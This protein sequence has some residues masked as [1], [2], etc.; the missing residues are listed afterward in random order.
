[1][2]QKYRNILFYTSIIGGGAAFIYWI[3]RQGSHLEEGRHIIRPEAAGSQWQA[4]LETITGNFLE[5]LAILL[6]QIIT[7]IIIARLLGWLFRKIGQPAVIGEIIAGIILGP[8]VVGTLFPDFFNGLFPVSSLA[9]LKTISNIGLIL[10][11]FVVGMELDLKVLRTKIHEAVVISHASIIFPFVL[12]MGLAYLLYGSFAP[13]GVPFISFALFM[14]ISMSITA[15]PVLARIVQERGLQKTRLG[16]VVLTCAAVD[17]I[18]AWCL[19][20]VVIAIVKA[21]SVVSSLYTVLFAIMYVIVMIK[22]VRPFLQKISDI[23]SSREN[24]N[25]SVVAVFFL[26]LLLSAF[27]TEIIGIHALFGAFMAGAIMPEKMNFRSIIVEKVEDVAL[28]IFL[29]LFFVYTG[30]R[31]KIGLINEPHLWEVT[32]WIILVAVIGKFAGSA[33]AGRYVG[34][35]TWK[36]SLIVGTLMNTRGLMELVAINIGYDLGVISAEIFTMLVIMAL[37]TTF[38]T[39]PLL[40]LIE[41]I[42]PDKSKKKEIERQQ[43]EGIFKVL[44]AVGK[45]KNG[46][47]F[48]RIAKKVL[49]GA[50]N[51]L[52][53]TAL[54]ITA[55]ADTNPIRSEQFSKEVFRDIENEAIALNVPL[56][57]EYNISDYVSSGIVNEANENGF[58]FLLFGSG[59]SYSEIPFLEDTSL[60]GKIGWLNRAINRIA[61]RRILFYP[62]TL[63]KDKTRYFIENTKCSVGMFINRG[64]S[65]ITTTLILLEVESDGFLLRYA[66]RLLRNANDVTITIYDVNNLSKTNTEIAEALD[67]LKAQF[68]N[69]V[70]ITRR[71]VAFNRFSFMLISYQAW[72]Y[73]DLQKSEE[74]KFIPSTLI[75][76]KKP[77]R[78]SKRTE[79][80]HSLT[81]STEE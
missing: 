35:Q 23:H 30:L 12:G 45:P 4:F 51:T 3:S 57:K 77:S 54:H 37:L 72:N 16:T 63:I 20:A 56:I 41:K 11:M 61:R 8:S 80:I 28:I 42:A 19:L 22:F 65:Q 79:V 34:R 74:L 21:G 66:R 32:G 15:F 49:D 67:N 24:L 76:N 48:L 53:V 60:F 43:A 58:D 25:K 13:M 59:V 1:M 5:P 69:S 75:I 50:R 38:M 73:Y 14:G 46:K 9:N 33:L 17:D 27:C 6:A 29:P 18:T 78:F 70:K 55:G 81:E 7:I 64:F 31:T 47:Y 71:K 2:Q 10:F 40:S 26:T 52:E 68:P 44:I 39:S 62:Q 36:D